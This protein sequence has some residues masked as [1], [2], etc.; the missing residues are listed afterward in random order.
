M[1]MVTSEDARDIA[2][3]GQSKAAVAVGGHHEKCTGKTACC[4]S[5]RKRHLDVCPAAIPV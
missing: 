1:T 4:F 2:H 5:A 3:C